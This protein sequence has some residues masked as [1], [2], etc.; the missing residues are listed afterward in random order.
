[1]QLYKAW[2]QKGV[3][4]ATVCASVEA[5]AAALGM[6]P[7][8]TDPYP[9]AKSKRNEALWQAPGTVFVRDYATADLAWVPG[10][11]PGQFIC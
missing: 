7:Q 5:A 4:H 11:A 1:M 9:T 2:N 6:Y 10:P 8:Y 3:C